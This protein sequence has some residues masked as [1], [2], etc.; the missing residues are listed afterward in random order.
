MQD[1]CY[2]EFNYACNVRPDHMIPV[3]MEPE[4]KDVSM[5]KGLLKSALGDTLYIDMTEITRANV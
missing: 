5:W 2:F 4:A 3:V 1:N